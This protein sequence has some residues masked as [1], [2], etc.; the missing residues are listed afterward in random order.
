MANLFVSSIFNI[1]GHQSNRIF[2][3][4]LAAGV[5]CTY[6]YLEFFP[7]TKTKFWWELYIYSKYMTYPHISWFV[8]TCFMSFFFLQRI[9]PSH[10][11]F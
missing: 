3:K 8:F 11:V 5:Y 4:L 2:K 1:Q 6:E 7:P 9:F 10:Q